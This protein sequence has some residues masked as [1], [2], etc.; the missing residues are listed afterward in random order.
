MSTREDAQTTANKL[1]TLAVLKKIVERLTAE[2]KASADLD[3]GD[4]K[5]AKAGKQSIGYV[6]LTDPKEAFRVTD[7][8]AFRAWVKEHRP[9]E[10]VTIESVNSAFEK[11][12]LERG[13][14]EAGE[15]IPGVELVAG[16]PVMQVRPTADAEAAI[17]AELTQT[18]LDF[19]G[20]LDA[21]TPAQITDSGDPS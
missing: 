20:V 13:C 18:G 8:R 16:A 6:L 1:V 21:L 5:S 9:D 11:A 19:V 7:G 15:S 3:P 14:D 17:R 12:I 4:R 2:V 10:I